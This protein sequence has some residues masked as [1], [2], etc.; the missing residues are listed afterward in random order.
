MVSGRE[1]H[2]GRG[3]V[4]VCDSAVRSLQPEGPV[5]RRGSVRS[6]AGAR[7]SLNQ[8]ASWFCQLLGFVLHARV[9]GLRSC[10]FRVAGRFARTR[11]G[12]QD[13]GGSGR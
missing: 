5:R 13:G 9:P 7:R 4:C 11:P 2:Y 10:A 3:C 8:A 1:Q 12:G 6:A